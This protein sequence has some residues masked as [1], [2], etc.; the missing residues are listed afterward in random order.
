MVKPWH[1]YAVYSEWVWHIQVASTSHLRGEVIIEY[2]ESI[3]AMRKQLTE[4]M[5]Q[6]GISY[7]RYIQLLDSITDMK[8][9]RGS[10]DPVS[11]ARENIE[12]LYAS[13]VAPKKSD[14]VKLFD[15]CLSQCKE[16]NKTL[17]LFLSHMTKP[18]PKSS[19]DL[20]SIVIALNQDL[21]LSNIEISRYLV[22]QGIR[23]DRRRVHKILK[24]HHIIPIDGRSRR[25]HR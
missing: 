3:E 21:K 8:D 4:R 12:R 10:I 18:K 16:H 14:I 11:Y 9:E 7:Q 6:W 23:C 1:H 25:Y 17:S 2:S 13:W 15:F 5:Y 22:W 19:I 20:E 24:A